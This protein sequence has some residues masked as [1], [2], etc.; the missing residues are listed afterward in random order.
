MC[1]PWSMCN[2]IIL[3]SSDCE[4]MLQF[5][6]CMFCVLLRK[7]APRSEQSAPIYEEIAQA[8]NL[9]SNS[10]TMTALY[11]D[12]QLPNSDANVCTYTICEAYGATRGTNECHT[13]SHDYEDIITSNITNN[14]NS[15]Y[16][17]TECP[18][19]GN[20]LTS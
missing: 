12:V 20:T 14:R 10:Q 6:P 19:Y 9:E 7:K 18:A 3:R 15:G 2:I 5:M 13:T 4:I 1:P 11:E 17:L 16:N 8:S